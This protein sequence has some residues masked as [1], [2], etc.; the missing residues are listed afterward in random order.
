MQR[1]YIKNINE[2]VFM[3]CLRVAPQHA[4]YRQFVDALGQ[5][6]PGYLLASLF[7]FVTNR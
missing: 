3:F 1:I 5:Q 2:Q 7:Y 6:K 4:F